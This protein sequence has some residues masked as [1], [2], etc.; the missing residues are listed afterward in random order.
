MNYLILVSHGQFA[1]GLKD[2][3]GMFVGDNITTVRAIGLQADEDTAQLGTR[4]ETLLASL[5]PD[6]KLVVLGDIIGGSPLTTIIDVLHA[7][8]R[9]SQTI[10]LGGMNFPMALNAAILKDSL[11][12]DEFVPAVLSEAASAVKPFE[13]TV[14]SADD[15]DEI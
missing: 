10:V 2:A 7:Q 6:A 1:D 5:E 3:L 9:L 13:L 8:G 12:P 14:D 11:S 15:D 4:F